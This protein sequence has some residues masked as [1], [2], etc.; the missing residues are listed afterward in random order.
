MDPKKSA[1][2]WSRR[3][4]VDPVFLD[5]R[6]RRDL[7]VF[8]LNCHL[9]TFPPHSVEP[10]NCPFNCWTSSREAVNTNFYCH[11][12]DSSGNLT[13][14]YRFRSACSLLSNS[15]WWKACD[16]RC[17]FLPYD[18]FGTFGNLNNILFSQVLLL[19][20]GGQEGIFNQYLVSTI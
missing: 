7:L 12:F 17:F 2:K 15:D 20:K 14:V 4:V 3:E 13:Q 9:L 8:E 11:W 5:R 16:N 1:P 19:R 6:Q 10:S 18:T